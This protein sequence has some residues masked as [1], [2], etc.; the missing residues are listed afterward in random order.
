M[1]KTY[2]VWEDALKELI[3]RCLEIFHNKSLKGERIRCQPSKS[4]SLGNKKSI[5]LAVSL[6]QAHACLEWR[7]MEKLITFNMTC[8]WTFQTNSLLH[9]DMF[10]MH[11]LHE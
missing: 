9:R 3:S 7:P 8:L 4:L 11:L 2:S 10:L 1:W 6:Q 5:A